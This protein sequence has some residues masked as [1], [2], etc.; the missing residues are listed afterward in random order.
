MISKLDDS[1]ISTTPKGDSNV[2]G[3]KEQ[4]LHSNSNLVHVEF[5]DFYGI[6]PS[7]V[8]RRFDQRLSDL[9]YLPK[10]KNPR[11]DWVV[12]AALNA[13]TAYKAAN[14][15]VV[16][17]FA[18]IGTGSGTDAIAALD[19]FPQLSAIAM[20]DMHDEVV[21][22][23]KSNLLTATEK[24]NKRV[25]SVA[26]HS[27][28][29]AGD[30]MSPLEGESAFDLIYEN[31]PNVPLTDGSLSLRSG[32]TSS[33]YVG[34]R[35]ADNIPP[36]VSTALLDLHYVCLVQARSSGLISPNGSI[37]SSIGGRIGLDEILAM[38]DAA[39]YTGRILSLSWKEQSEPESVIGGY[40]EN[41]IKSG[42]Q[43]RFYPVSVLESVFAGQTPA[44]AGLRGFQIE[45]ELSSFRLSAT[46]AL[47][48]HHQ[49]VRIGHTVVV[50]ASTPRN[51]G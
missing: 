26:K 15:N 3:L 39:G 33:T 31:L 7:V 41:E 9:S 42:K 23:A 40:A 43:F 49:G 22:I 24:S 4:E 32:Q 21:D 20:T 37:L 13:F 18:T 34:D 50:M 48:K 45:H 17:R 28:A 47:D 14:Y 1:A 16:R 25:R 38:A 10:V 11:A 30:L 5:E 27:I 2:H 6:E 12:T 29:K 35:G 8:D 51:M 36:W 44:G 46:E 19:L